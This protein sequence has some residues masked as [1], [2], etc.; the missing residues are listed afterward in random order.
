[1]PEISVN[2]EPIEPEEIPEGENGGVAYMEFDLGFR[3]MAIA[4]PEDA[5]KYDLIVVEVYKYSEAWNRGLRVDHQILKIGK[6]KVEDLSGLEELMRRNLNDKGSV[7]LEII[8]KD[9]A[10]GFIE[11]KRN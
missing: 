6:E 11:L 8:N 4:T 9:D 3:V 5:E 2:V 1:V 7:T 10:R